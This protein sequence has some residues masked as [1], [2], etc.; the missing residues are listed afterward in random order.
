MRS[1]P[2]EIAK[3][4]KFIAAFP[5]APVLG[6]PGT[7]VTGVVVTGVVPVPEPAAV[8]STVPD[9]GSAEPLLIEAAGVINDPLDALVAMMPLGF[10]A[11][12]IDEPAGVAAATLQVSSTN[13]PDPAGTEN[14]VSS[15][16]VVTPP[17]VRSVLTALLPLFND[18]AKFVALCNEQ[19]V[20]SAG[21]APLSEMVI[22]REVTF[23]LLPEPVP[24]SVKIPKI[25]FCV[26]A[27]TLGMVLTVTP[28][29][30][31]SVGVPA[32]NPKVVPE[33]AD[34]FTLQLTVSVVVA[35][36]TVSGVSNVKMFV[37]LPRVL[38]M[39][40]PEVKVV[41]LPF[42]STQLVRLAVDAPDP[43]VTVIG[44]ELIM[45]V[46][47]LFAESMIVPK[48]VP[49]EPGV[50]PF[51]DSVVV[52]LTGPAGADTT[53]ADAT[54]AEMTNDAVMAATPN[55]LYEAF[56]MIISKYC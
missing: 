55:I 35:P 4:A 49:V 20:R 18:V 5:P 14:G 47:P 36:V 17:L 13:C 29:L 52:T 27:A 28:R 56:I 3:R 39:L 26:P 1:T 31:E 33:E 9:T 21:V 44:N 2:A 6:A 51:D 30:G 41:P 25:A 19:L 16:K 43:G 34:E 37:P 10:T 7:A 48:F 24:S 23:V 32:T 22:G 45:Y 8:T 15:V 38:T 54:P 42:M 50:M 12:V 40:L 46:P 53:C 11:T